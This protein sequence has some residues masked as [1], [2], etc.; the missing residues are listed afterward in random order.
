MKN[1]AT[2]MKATLVSI[3]QAHRSAIKSRGKTVSG[4]QEERRARD[5]AAKNRKNAPKCR[6]RSIEKELES[7]THHV[8]RRHG[9]HREQVRRDVSSQ[10]R[11]A[12]R[13]YK[14]DENRKASE[15]QEAER[16]KRLRQ[17]RGISC[18]L[19]QE[20]S[21]I[22]AQLWAIA[23][24]KRTLRRLSVTDL[25]L[26]QGER[27]A[28]CRQ[29]R[30][31]CAQATLKREAR[32]SPK[33]ANSPHLHAGKRQATPLLWRENA[34]KWSRSLRRWRERTGLKSLSRWASR[35]EEGGSGQSGQVSQEARSGAR[36]RV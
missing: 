19:W 14:L 7:T 21:K 1:A 3:G 13:E 35:H 5:G 17:P 6:A 30:K 23:K 12:A 15:K 32:R 31:T 33:S 34:K 24:R 26:R 10:Q 11:G 36:A 16:A 29:G 8:R 27:A 9:A 20:E 18:Y 4:N 25:S 22:R 28:T 2:K